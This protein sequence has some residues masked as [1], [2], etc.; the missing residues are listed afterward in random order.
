M[1]GIT[2]Y[3]ILKN[4]STIITFLCT[5]YETKSDFILSDCHLHTIF[6][7]YIGKKLYLDYDHS[8]TFDGEM[9]H[10]YKGNDIV[11][12][13]Y[14]ECFDALPEELQKLNKSIFT[15]IVISEKTPLD[16]IDVKMIACLDKNFM[17]IV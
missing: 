6:S 4:S 16:R 2:P 17:Y 12:Q 11:N 1:N 15:P 10:Y 5:G 7:S 8:E 3:I 9:I 14:K 13:L